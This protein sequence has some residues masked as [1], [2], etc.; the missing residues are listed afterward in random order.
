MDKNKNNGVER[1][2]MG[3]KVHGNTGRKLSQEH[4]DKISKGCSNPSKETRLKISKALKGHIVSEETRRKIG[5]KQKGKIVSIETREKISKANKGK[6]CWNKGIKQWKNGDHPRGM[7]GKKNPHSKETCKKISESNMGRIIKKESR[8]QISNTLK[9]YYKNNPQVIEEM[10]KRRSNQKTPKKD[11]T[12]EVI[13]QN[14]LKDL[15]IEFFTHQYM[16][17]EHAYQCDVYIPSMNLVIEVDGDYWHG[18]PEKYSDEQLNQRQMEQRERDS[19]RT[20]ELIEKGY[21]VIRIWEN[22]IRIM[23]INQFKEKIM[24]VTI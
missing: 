11:T 18:N 7:L 20:R 13:V 10:K 17:I 19:A 4:K 14:F 2:S 5:I 22:E 6:I 9:K 24:E 12:I 1:E 21:N 3:K 16:R 8:I 23:N 15:E